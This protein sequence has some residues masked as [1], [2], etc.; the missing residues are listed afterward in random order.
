MVRRPLSKRLRLCSRPSIH[1]EEKVVRDIRLMTSLHL[2]VADLRHAELC[3]LG[4]KFVGRH[5]HVRAY[6]KHLVGLSRHSSTFS[7][8]NSFH[9]CYHRGNPLIQ[10]P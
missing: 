1:R 7:I 8:T 3:V 4:R 5:Y 10:S 6:P 2:L 9:C